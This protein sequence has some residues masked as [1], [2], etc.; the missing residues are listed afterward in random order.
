M[1]SFHLFQLNDIISGGGGGV[2]SGLS[3]FCHEYIIF[4]E[5]VER[6]TT[7]VLNELVGGYDVVKGTSGIPEFQ[8][9]HIEDIFL[10]SHIHI[11]FTLGAIKIMKLFCRCVI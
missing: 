7:S 3:T 10:T 5:H 9:K 11:I 1:L 4:I 6:V 8:I 2:S